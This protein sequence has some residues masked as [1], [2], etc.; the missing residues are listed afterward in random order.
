MANIFKNHFDRTL[1]K[2]GFDGAKISFTLPLKAPIYMSSLHV[3]Q[4]NNNYME[5]MR[6]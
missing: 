1:S 3:S 2:F 6:K 5:K 4:S